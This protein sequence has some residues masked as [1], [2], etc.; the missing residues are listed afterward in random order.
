MRN[1]I[2]FLSTFTLTVLLA[3]F[4]STPANALTIPAV[5]GACLSGW[6]L[7][8]SGSC[9]SNSTGNGAG[10]SW[11]C[12]DGWTTKPDGSCSFDGGGGGGGGGG[13]GGFSRGIDGGRSF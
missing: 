1:L 4:M 5:D 7:N 8:S 11:G 3:V 12:P 9:T 10:G 13:S 6:T 2:I